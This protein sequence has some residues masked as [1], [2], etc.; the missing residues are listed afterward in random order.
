MMNKESLSVSVR[1]TSKLG[2]TSGH[3]EG[4]FRAGS[5]QTSFLLILRLD[6]QHFSGFFATKIPAFISS[7]SKSLFGGVFKLFFSM[8]LL[9]H[10][11][12]VKG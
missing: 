1:V 4:R 8:Y 3:G 5:S 9:K 11:A 6:G 10:T 12:H 2:L 7:G